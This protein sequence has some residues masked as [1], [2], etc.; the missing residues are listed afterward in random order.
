MSPAELSPM[1]VAAAPN[2]GDFLRLTGCPRCESRRRA[3][4]EVAGRLRGR[5]LACGEELTVPL[6]VETTPRF[7]LVGR[8]G[9]SHAGQFTDE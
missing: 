6:S 4:V 1:P 2:G 3:L 5:C 8:A 9:H 7:E